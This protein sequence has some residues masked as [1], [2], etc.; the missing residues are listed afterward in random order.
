MKQYVRDD[1]RNLVIALVTMKKL[2]QKCSFEN[3]NMVTQTKVDRELRNRGD[4]GLKS[5][6]IRDGMLDQALR[7][8]FVRRARDEVIK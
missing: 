2:L 6:E 8:D 1:H 7:K 3:S 4:T 5:K